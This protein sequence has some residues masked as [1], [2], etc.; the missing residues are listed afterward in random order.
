MSGIL[1]NP[2]ICLHLL[3]ALADFQ[4]TLSLISAKNDL[5]NSSQSNQHPII[6]YQDRF[7]SHNIL[8]PMSLSFYNCMPYALQQASQ[9]AQQ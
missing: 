5:E 2:E 4:K 9:M 3:P 7:C 6:R 8:F 1:A